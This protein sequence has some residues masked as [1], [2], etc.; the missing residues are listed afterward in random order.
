MPIS[1]AH[2]DLSERHQ[3]VSGVVSLVLATGCMLALPVVQS[4]GMTIGVTLGLLTVLFLVVG[5]LSIGTSD[6]PQV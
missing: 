4:A 5:T 1:T 6:Q 2:A 3:L